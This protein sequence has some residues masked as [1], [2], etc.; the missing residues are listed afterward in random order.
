MRK[1][2]FTSQKPEALAHQVLTHGGIP[3]A[4]KTSSFQQ[5]V[6]RHGQLLESQRLLVLAPSPK[7]L[8]VFG[9][10]ASL[11]AVV[12]PGERGC[13]RGGF[14]QVPEV[15][16]QVGPPLDDMLGAER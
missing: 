4:E 9:L 5:T 15:V 2:F 13:W 3:S 14:D 8:E 10:F 7:I 11:P 6:C 12:L 16:A 1:E